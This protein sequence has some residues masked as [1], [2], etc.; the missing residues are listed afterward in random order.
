M[1]SL[2][3]Y[4]SSSLINQQEA[5]GPVLSEVL[6]TS[7]GNSVIIDS[8][9]FPSGGAEPDRLW[10]SAKE[11]EAR[12]P[13]GQLTASTTIPAFSDE[14]IGP[15]NIGTAGALPTLLQGTPNSIESSDG[16]Y[17][18]STLY[19]QPTFIKIASRTL[20][21]GAAAV[22]TYGT[23]LE[24]G[25]SPA[26][27]EGSLSSTE[28]SANTILGTTEHSPLLITPLVS[29]STDS[30]HGVLSVE[31]ISE[32]TAPAS[33][34]IGAMST[35]SP[36][37]ATVTVDGMPVSLDS[38]GELFIGTKGPSGGVGSLI[39]GGLQA[40]GLPATSSITNGQAGSPT[41][42]G[43][44]PIIATPSRSTAK[45]TKN[46]SPWRMVTI[47]VALASVWA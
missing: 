20:A 33:T 24:A 22:S 42:P 6:V 40:G 13:G 1:I 23:M 3:S 36:G 17:A 43:T 10:L 39:I 9:G 31:T 29:S 18:Q 45:G 11:S 26:M 25:A 14:A 32:L 12:N 41:A 7:T 35:L 4:G 30:E 15:D 2:Q 19:Q 46:S 5:I 27:L 37:A 28:N 34:A 47:L 21:N 38:S 16:I 8:F 44:I